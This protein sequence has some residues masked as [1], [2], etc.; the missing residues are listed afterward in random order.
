MLSTYKAI[1]VAVMV[2]SSTVAI[3]NAFAQAPPVLPTDVTGPTSGGV[4]PSGVMRNLGVSGDM[5][6]GSSMQVQGNLWYPSQ[7]AVRTMIFPV[8]VPR[9]Y[10]YGAPNIVPNY[11]WWGR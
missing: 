6:D 11:Y 1:A 4:G 2:A 5:L 9:S 7:P 10:Q 8:V 3:Q